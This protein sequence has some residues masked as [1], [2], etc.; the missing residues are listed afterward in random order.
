MAQRG[1]KVSKHI[2]HPLNNVSKS[3]SITIQPELLR[4][5][6]QVPP[7]A[8][9]SEIYRFLRLR[10]KSCDELNTKQVRS[11]AHRVF[12]ILAENRNHPVP[13]S[14]HVHVT[15]SLCPLDGNTLQSGLDEEDEFDRAFIPSNIKVPLRYFHLTRQYL[16]HPIP[17]ILPTGMP[18]TMDIIISQLDSN[19]PGLP[20]PEVRST[21]FALDF[22]I[23]EIL[24][25][26]RVSAISASTDSITDICKALYLLN[27]PHNTRMEIKNKLNHQY[28]CMD[29]SAAVVARSLLY[30]SPQFLSITPIRIK[31]EPKWPIA[32]RPCWFGLLITLVNGS[33]TILP[34][35]L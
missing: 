26:Q 3:P 24:S 1:R 9:Q 17:A 21:T 32:S 16:D 15:S 20:P 5:A 19:H 4:L 34:V 23:K 14:S 31:L 10:D 8:D 7:T 11:R 29:R 33:Q 6:E 18:L 35:C 12:L 25:H 13:V 27:P 28:V 30:A 2:L 22:K